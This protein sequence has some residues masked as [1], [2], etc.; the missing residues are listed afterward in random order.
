MKI[1]RQEQTL[2]VSELEQLTGANALS[3]RSAVTAALGPD[4][5]HIALDLSQTELFDCGGLGV[6]VALRKSLRQDHADATVSLVNPTLPVRR[7]LQLTR[8]DR[9]FSLAVSEPP[10][11]EPATH[12]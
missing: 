1:V 9:L 5:R 12:F 11:V 3:L 7:L 6:L 4:V 10:P 8:A 2:T